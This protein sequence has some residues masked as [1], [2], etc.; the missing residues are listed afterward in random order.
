VT[1]AG[2]QFGGIEKVGGDSG[3]VV[4]CG[5]MAGGAVP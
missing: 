2:R 1:P 4:G 5:V 3:G